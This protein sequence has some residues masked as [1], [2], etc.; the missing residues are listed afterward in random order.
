M[1]WSPTKTRLHSSKIMQIN[2]F[3]EGDLRRCNS[4]TIGAWSVCLRVSFNS[5]Q[6]RNSIN[7]KFQRIRAQGKP[8]MVRR[9]Y[10]SEVSALLNVLHWL[11]LS[12]IAIGTYTIHTWHFSSS[13][14]CNECSENRWNSLCP[15]SAMQS[16]SFSVVFLAR[17]CQG[18]AHIVA[19]KGVSM[20]SLIM[21][22]AA[23][24]ITGAR[25][26]QYAIIQLFFRFCRHIRFESS[27]EKYSKITI[28]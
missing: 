21:L 19:K 23:A 6:F 9:W 5:H 28:Q 7:N 1:L 25:P 24:L 12:D 4:A 2:N 18:N 15:A 13:Q 27:R 17:N 14:S 16:V 20:I 3:I 10:W 8:D 22:K 11:K 26:L